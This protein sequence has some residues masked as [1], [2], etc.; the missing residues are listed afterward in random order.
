MATK[1]L[2]VDLEAYERLA[3]VDERLA[4]LDTRV[5]QA[6]EMLARLQREL[7]EA[8]EASQ[9]LTVADLSNRPLDEL[10]TLQTNA[11]VEL[12]QLQSQLAEVN[13]QLLA[14]QTLV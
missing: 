14:A 8:E 12:Q 6:P 9:Q 7:S 3:S 5:E 10:E 4:A 13:S 11:V 1:T 2:S